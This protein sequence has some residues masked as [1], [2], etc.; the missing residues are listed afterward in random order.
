MRRLAFALTLLIV[1][2]AC[3]GTNV[4]F[5]HIEELPPATPESVAALLA[6]SDKPIVVNVWASW[7]IPCRSEA[8]LLERASEEFSGRVTFVG[9]NFRDNQNGARAFIAEFFPDAPIFHLSDSTDR[10]PVELGGT[11]G[12]PQT[13]FYSAGGQLVAVHPAVIDER[14]LVLQI[15]EILGRS[16]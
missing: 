7:C 10:I 8:P 12:V 2:G 11:F 5:S 14:T 1:L 6:A 16:R 9:L 13:F 4:D 3:G 15:D